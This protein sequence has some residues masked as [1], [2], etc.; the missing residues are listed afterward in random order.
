MQYYVL[1]TD[2]KQIDGMFMEVAFSTGITLVNEKL[3]LCQYF[4]RLG[5]RYDPK[6]RKSNKCIIYV[7][8]CCL[9]GSF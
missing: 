2:S 9:R 6:R 8:K 1:M 5:V 7:M 3:V 4:T